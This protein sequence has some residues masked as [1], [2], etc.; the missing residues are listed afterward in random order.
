M[1]DRPPTPTALRRMIRP[2]YDTETSM[3]VTPDRRVNILDSSMFET[4]AVGFLNHEKNGLYRPRIE[5]D[6]LLSYENNF[7]FPLNP[8]E[9]DNGDPS[10]VHGISFDQEELY[11]S[12]FGNDLPFPSIEE[13][14]HNGI[15][16]DN[17][18]LNELHEVDSPS[19]HQVS[20]ESTV[21]I[22]PKKPRKG[23]KK[24]DFT[25][26]EIASLEFVQP[27]PTDVLGGRGQYV[28]DNPGNQRLQRVVKTFQPQ[29]WAAKRNM[30]KEGIAHR[31]LAEVEA[32]GH[33]FLDPYLVTG[34]WFVPEYDRRLEKV[35]Q[36]LRSRN[37]N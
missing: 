36:I 21:S 26:E 14:A 34:G 3:F 15:L 35:K 31:A 4:T 19:N 28:K 27:K 23:A 37:Q 16:A 6:V 13:S 9:E 29:Y 32:G 2:K 8:E 10:H 7:D 24:K 17:D 5:N 25:P 22:S 30:V 33:R 20:N 1:S 12:A 18:Q 11:W